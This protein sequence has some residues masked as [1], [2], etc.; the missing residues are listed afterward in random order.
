MLYSPLTLPSIGSLFTTLNERR[1]VTE[2]KEMSHPCLMSMGWKTK[3]S[4]AVHIGPE[5]NPDVAALKRAVGE[6]AAQCGL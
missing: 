6:G 1:A 3:D 2:D 5:G 4:P